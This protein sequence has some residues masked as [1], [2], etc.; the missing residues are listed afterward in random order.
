MKNTLY[1]EIDHLQARIAELEGDLG[2][3]WARVERLEHDLETIT[4]KDS[5]LF[6]RLELK[7]RIKALE[8]E[9]ETLRRDNEFL[10]GV[11]GYELERVRP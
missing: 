5:E 1:A 10:A 6:Q 9:N 7:G 4:V 11:V 8:S 3:A 2:H